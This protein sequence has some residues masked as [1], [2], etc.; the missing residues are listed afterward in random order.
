[1]LRQEREVRSTVRDAVLT[2]RLGFRYRSPGDLRARLRA[3]DG[4]TLVGLEIPKGLRE[5]YTQ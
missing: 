4:L 2:S 5:L 3:R 1:M